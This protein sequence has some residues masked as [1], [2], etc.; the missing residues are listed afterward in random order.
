MCVVVCA[1]AIMRRLCVDDAC[2]PAFT[3]VC[4]GVQE[5]CM[6]ACICEHVC[7]YVCVCVKECVLSFV[8]I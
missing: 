3:C 2:V 7:V 4:V 6:R 8:C 1:L 5:S